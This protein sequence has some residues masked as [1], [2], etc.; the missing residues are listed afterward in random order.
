MQVLFLS[1]RLV[2]TVPHYEHNYGGGFAYCSTCLTSYYEV[3]KRRQKEV[4][5]GDICLYNTPNTLLY[6]SSLTYTKHKH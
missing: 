2:S 4:Q 3:T 6:F 5:G 1:R